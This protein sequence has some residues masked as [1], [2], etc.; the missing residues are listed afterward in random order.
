MPLSVESQDKVKSSRKQI[1]LHLGMGCGVSGLYPGVP[2]PR[3][4]TVSPEQ[5]FLRGK[6]KG[7]GLILMKQV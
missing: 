1:I 7:W 3:I 6:G 4:L 2:L 5:S